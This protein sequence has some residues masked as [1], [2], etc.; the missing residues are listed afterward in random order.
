MVS[1][2]CLLQLINI[3]GNLQELDLSSCR[4]VTSGG[5]IP[6]GRLIK[7]R[8]LSL[9]RTRVADAALH[10]LANLCQHLRHLNLGSCVSIEDADTI[11]EHITASNPLLESL[12]LWRCRNLTSFGVLRIAEH[13]PHLLRLDLGWCTG[14]ESEPSTCLRELVTRCCK[15]RVLS[16]AAIRSVTPADVDA[17]ADSLHDSLVDLDLIGNAL[18]T[19]SCINRLL[20]HC[21]KLA[22][23]DI[24]HCPSI[25]IFEALSL[26]AIYNHCDIAFYHHIPLPSPSLAMPVD[27]RLP[28]LPP[29]QQF[30]PLKLLGPQED[31][32]G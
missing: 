26:K 30:P 9:Y 15:I 11:V 7:L 4:S 21:R 1:D 5:F 2:E 16:L 20:L 32:D 10:N 18:I 13:C 25:S 12:V 27:P 3:C 8:W 17:I 22:F 6:L 24:S 29:P 31:L 19:Q 23:L 28:R 14:V